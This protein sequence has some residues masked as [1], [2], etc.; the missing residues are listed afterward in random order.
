[1]QW[2]A[3][4]NYPRPKFWGDGL[5]AGA[6]PQPGNEMGRCCRQSLLN[7]QRRAVSL[8]QR[9]PCKTLDGLVRYGD[10]GGR[11]APE[12]LF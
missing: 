3:T 11:C 9:C 4:T 1:M 2:L 6:T 7:D 12:S 10:A 5:Q 8:C